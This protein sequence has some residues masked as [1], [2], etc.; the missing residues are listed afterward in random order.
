MSVTFSI[1]YQAPNEKTE[2]ILLRVNEDVNPEWNIMIYREL[3]L[4]STG[5]YTFSLSKPTG[6]MIAS[7]SVIIKE[8]KLEKEMPEQPKAEG[9][10]LEALFNK[11]KPKN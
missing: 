2:G 3:P 10:T 6:E 9:T 4:P 5:R 7:D 1:Y 11:Y 8:K